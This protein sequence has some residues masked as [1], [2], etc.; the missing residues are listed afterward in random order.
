MSERNVMILSS[1]RTIDAITRTE[2]GLRY[3]LG[4]P[5]EADI[6]EKKPQKNGYELILELLSN[7][8]Q[9]RAKVGVRYMPFC[10]LILK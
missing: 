9:T 4:E 3:L 7:V 6:E 10:R 5:L 1:C 8:Q 2:L